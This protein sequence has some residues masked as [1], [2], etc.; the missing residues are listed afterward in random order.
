MKKMV[1]A[2]LAALLLVGALVALAA[3]AP[4]IVP[5]GG[6]YVTRGDYIEQ[7]LPFILEARRILRG[8]LNS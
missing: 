4:A 6:Q 8:G 2:A 7:Q 1:I 3:L 5:Y